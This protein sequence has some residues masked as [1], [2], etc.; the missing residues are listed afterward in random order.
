[1]N[2]K[3]ILMFVFGMFLFSLTFV[4]AETSYCAERT[5]TGLWCQNVPL[6]QVDQ[7]FQSSPTS[8]EAT[9]YCGLGC[10][11]DSNEGTCMRNTPEIVCTQKQGVWQDSASCEVPQCDLGCCLIGTEAAF[12]PKQRCKKLSSIYGLDIIFRTDIT[13]EVQCILSTTSDKKG[14][15]VFEEEFQTTC[16]F[17]TKKECLDLKLENVSFHEDYLCSAPELGTDCART[18]KT[19]C[20]DGKDGV[21]FLDSCGNVANI[22]DASRIKDPLYWTKILDV[23]GSCNSAG[24]NA[25]SATCGNCDY[26]LGSTCKSYAR[27]TDKKRPQY[28]DNICRN[29]SCNFEGKNYQHGETWCADSKGLKNTLPGSRA[30]RMVCY[31][32][33]VS[34]EP[35]ADFRQ[36][37]CI[38][39]DIDGFSTAACRANRW[40]DCVNQE[41]K[42]DCENLDKRD[43]TWISGST[44]QCV[45]NFAPGFDFWSTDEGGQAE[46][47]CSQASVTCSVTCE[48]GLS[49]STTCESTPKGCGD[50]KGLNAAW[51]AKQNLVCG[52]LGDCGV[53]LNYMGQKGFN[54]IGD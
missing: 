8:C 24:S 51:E 39:S 37:V 10:C 32:G 27:S 43:C 5:I 49:G 48:K 20:V 9:K 29:L 1:M 17:T 25:D 44:V 47:I 14:A 11:Y 18:E 23:G 31:N 54:E 22:Y 46:E 21:F 4:S 30:F 45:P 2:K 34:V 53:K 41:K 3:I 52:G 7:N 12:V 40:Q 50:E 42:K 38:Q 13:N 19:T 28:G 36:E 15:C 26:Y 33:E 16:K 35:C 6:S